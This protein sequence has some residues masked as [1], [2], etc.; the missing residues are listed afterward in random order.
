M[1]IRTIYIAFLLIIF[2][3]SVYSQSFRSGSSVRANINQFIPKNLSVTNLSRSPALVHTKSINSVWA[4][5][6]WNYVGNAQFSY[7]ADG[8]PTRILLID[9]TKLLNLVQTFYNYD[10]YKNSTGTIYE[11]WNTLTSK[12]YTMC[13]YYQVYSNRKLYQYDGSNRITQ[14]IYQV[15]KNGWLNNSREDYILNASGKYST[16]TV[17]NWGGTNWIPY[18][19]DTLCIWHG[20]ILASF[21]EKIP[22]IS[23]GWQ[24]DVR[25]NST[26]TSGDNFVAI[27]E[28]IFASNWDSVYRFTR[29]YDANGGYSHI[30]EQYSNSTWEKA[31]RTLYYID[32]LGNYYGFRNDE[33][34]NSNWRQSKGTFIKHT[35]NTNKVMLSEILSAYSTTTDTL[36]LQEK[37]IFT[38]FQYPPTVSVKVINKTTNIKIYPNPA[39]DLI[40]IEN[41][42]SD[43]SGAAINIYDINGR[44]VM[45]RVINK[46][47]NSVQ[48]DLNGFIQGVYL[49]E[50]KNGNDFSRSRILIK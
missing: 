3:L 10:A 4:N 32:S 46:N 48:I 44:Q 49:L 11:A 41:I 26:F 40:N 38:E 35:Y 12:L 9:T 50:V 14:T 47:E 19:K 18:Y 5:S 37:H 33:W 45:N 34:Y 42:V 7:D 21:L 30:I 28:S 23:G 13:T 22:S 43:K 16:M 39:T 20:D 2:S 24:D 27:Y 15:W 25:Y 8:L 17:Y 1:K 6:I 31:Y 29:I 36:E